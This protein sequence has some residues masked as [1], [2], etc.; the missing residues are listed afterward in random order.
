MQRKQSKKASLK[1]YSTEAVL[2]TRV[3]FRHWQKQPVK[4]DWVKYVKVQT[5][6]NVDG[7][8]IGEKS[9]EVSAIYKTDAAAAPVGVTAAPASI[10]IN[11]QKL[12]LKDGVDVYSAVADT[13]SSVPLRS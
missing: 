11:G 7:G 9:T 4:L 8:G 5:A 12:A 2:Y 10:S 13:A 3:R 6:S 1:Y